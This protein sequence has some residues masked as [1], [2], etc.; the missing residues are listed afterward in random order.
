MKQCLVGVVW[1]LTLAAATVH[2][3]SPRLLRDGGDVFHGGLVGASRAERDTTYLLGGP[4]RLDGKFQD[5]YGNPS[6]HGW[7]HVDATYLPTPRW[8][9]S[10]FQSPTGTPAI[11]CG[12]ASFGNACGAGYGNDWNENLVFTH[13]V[14]NP[15]ANTIVRLECI[16]NWD[17]EP[18]FDYFRIQQNR[19]GTW[20]TI[21]ERDDVGSATFD[22]N[23]TFTPSD[24]VGPAWS[25]LELRFQ[26]SS[27]GAWSDEDCFW[28]TDGLAQVDDIRV[29]VDGQTYADDFDDGTSQHWQE[30]EQFGCGDFA[31]IWQNLQDVDPCVTNNSAQVAFIDD[32]VVV[33]GTGG[34]P[35]L[36]WCYGPGGYIVNNTGGLAGPEHHLDNLLLSPVMTWP[37]GNDGAILSY[38]VY[39]HEELVNGISPGIFYQWHV[40]STDSGD[41]ADL[42]QAAWRDRN[43]IGYGKSYLSDV[44]TVSDLLVPGRTHVQVGLR[45]LEY[46]WVFGW[47]GTDGT[48]APYFDNVAFKVFPFEGPAIAARAID[49]AQDGFPERGVLDLANLANNWVRFDMARTIAPGSHLRNDPGDSIIVDVGLLR[50]GSVLYDR[51]LMIVKMK[52]NPLFDAVRVL[53][54][55]FAQMGEVIDG[56]V[57]GDSTFLPS[58]AVL[59]NRFH[60]DLPD[61]NFLFPGD[62]LR[63]YIQAQDFLAGDV[64]TAT[65]PADLEAF[66]DI[67]DELVYP[68]EFVVR[69]L[70]T[71]E[72]AGGRQPEILFWNDAGRSVAAAWHYALSGFVH[73]TYETNGPS[74]GVGNGLGGRAT[75]S[76]LQGYDTLLYTCGDL[77]YFTLSNGDFNGD[78]SRDIA[79]LTNWFEHGEKHAFLSGD[80]LVHSLTISGY[81]AQTF[82]TEYLGVDLVHT[83]VGPLIGNQVNPRVAV[84]AGNSLGMPDAAAWIASGGCPGI[85]DFDAVTPRAGTETVAR[86]CNPS[87]TPDYPFAAVWRHHD[88]AD[89]IALPHDLAAMSAAP[90]WTPP[91]YP[92]L[93]MR[94]WFLTEVLHAFGYYSWYPAVPEAGVLTVSAYPNP[95]NPRTTITLVLPQ[96]GDA[97]LKLYDIRGRLVRTLLDDQLAEGRHDLVWNGDDDAGRAM[98]SGVYFYEARTAGEERIGKLTLVR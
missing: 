72:N 13:T 88:V 35:C 56:W 94:Q 45:C 95:F 10:D 81:A 5:A 53:P 75:G 92:Q 80:D 8:H 6:W 63:Y 38:D 79:V 62:V 77:T 66:P 47:E 49:L 42:D 41:P 52:A 96:A 46:G 27:D 30:V 39:R 9:V 12:Q 83:N 78:P 7:T 23:I 71:L 28:D 82:R 16:S 17:S 73:D 22:Q 98:A 61:S 44:Q 58:G 68:G 55:T 97:A 25:Q 85:N 93:A 57:Y 84:V 50:A 87:G 31:K 3:A 4:G 86:F 21:I 51:P 89:V 91:G 20:Q 36:S 14:A 1:C 26:G 54:P 74:S 24:Y 65:L 70:P 48:P 19:G 18:G 67:Y 40:R 32:G 29:T 33:P 69:A 37:A 15:G 76:V 11:W 59:P 60:F 64:G 2:G 90:D 34:T 43:Y